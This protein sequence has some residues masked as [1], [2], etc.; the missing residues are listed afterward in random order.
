VKIEAYE[1]VMLEK[2]EE[3]YGIFFAHVAAGMPLSNACSIFVT[4]AL[5]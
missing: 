3:K 4:A 1:S 2:Q 5:L